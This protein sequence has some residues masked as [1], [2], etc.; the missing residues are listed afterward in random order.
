M[1]CKLC[2]NSITDFMIL[3]ICGRCMDV[4]VTGALKEKKRKVA[5]TP[6]PAQEI[7]VTTESETA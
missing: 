4:L 2:D 7:E 1:N 6:E 5:P 3:G